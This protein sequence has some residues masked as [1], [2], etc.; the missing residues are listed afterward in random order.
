MILEKR[1]C[2]FSIFKLSCIF[3][4]IERF[5]RKE[6]QLFFPLMNKFLG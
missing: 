1:V 2:F 3:F 4:K 6:L 5:F